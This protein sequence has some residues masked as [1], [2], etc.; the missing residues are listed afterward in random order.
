MI[1]TLSFLQF[2]RS[3]GEGI[4]VISQVVPHEDKYL[5][6][7]RVFY[8]SSGGNVLMAK[9]PTYEGLEKKVKDLQI[10]ALDCK[11]AQEALRN[12]EAIYRGIIEYTKSGFAVYRPL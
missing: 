4:W 3:V 12:S 10:Q 5:G 11:R 9:K 6:L 7:M 8:L 1:E 2:S